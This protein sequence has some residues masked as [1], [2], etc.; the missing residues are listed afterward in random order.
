LL[1]AYR[2]QLSLLGVQASHHVDRN[3]SMDA[4]S[5]IKK[6]ARIEKSIA[7]CD[8]QKLSLFEAYHSDTID[9]E[10]FLE[11]KKALSDQ[12]AQL[13]AEYKNAE[14]EY[15]EKKQEFERS[16]EE[17][18]LIDEYLTGQSLPNDKAL[19]KM[20]EA[21]DRVTIYGADE[22]EIRW[23]FDDLFSSMQRSPMEKQAI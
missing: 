7:A 9:L 20:Y 5:Y 15:A 21:I 17:S 19:E 12:Q 2:V 8:T 1:P 10:V 16:Q 3:K 23:K 14:T 22:I 4:H 11:R 18:R 13:Q 6:M